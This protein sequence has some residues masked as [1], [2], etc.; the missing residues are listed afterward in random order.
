MTVFHDVTAAGQKIALHKTSRKTQ[1]VTHT[2]AFKQIKQSG[3]KDFSGADGWIFIVTS[4]SFQSL[5]S[6]KWQQLHIYGQ[7]GQY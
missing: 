3:Y 7:C 6:A 1:T 4:P 2:W 5:C